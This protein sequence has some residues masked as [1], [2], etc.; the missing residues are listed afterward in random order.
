ML[1]VAPLLALGCAAGMGL[2]AQTE[3]IAERLDT[4]Q[5]PAYKCAE[6]ALAIARSHVDF[7]RQELD[8]GDY[9][10]AKEHVDLAAD[11]AVQAEAVARRPECQEDTDGDG[12]PDPS[13]RCPDQAEDMDGFEDQ[14]GCPEDQDTD[15]DGIPDSRDQCPRDP[16]D[17]DGEQDDD[18][19]PDVAL[20]RDGDGIPDKDDKCPAQPEDKDGFEDLDG[21]PDPDNDQ[22]GVLDGQDGC[23]LQAEDKDGFED[24]NGCPDPDNDQDRIAD[25]VDQCPN[26]PEDYDGDADEDGCPDIYKAIV[27]KDDR[28]EL[29]QK[30]FFATGKDRILER[31]FDLLNEVAAALRER[32]TLRV[33]IEGHTDSQGSASYNQQ[34]SDRRAASVRRYLMGQGIDPDRMV[35]VGVGEDQPIEDNRTSEGR[36][37]NRRVEFHIIK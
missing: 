19:C 32:K 3:S 18:G 27:I 1:G 28:I 25:A 31:S 26:D 4:V 15:G 35:S 33:R 13:D 7:A 36:A 22:D 20:D 14:D 34:L 5:K 30:V 12:I 16:E 23:P 2:R 6:R 9:F 24:E 21:C 37:A 10:R 11:A 29:K 17:L 8:E